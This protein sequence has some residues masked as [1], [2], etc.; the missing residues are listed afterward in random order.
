VQQIGVAR[1]LDYDVCARV[2]VCALDYR[3]L[4]HDFIRYVAFTAVA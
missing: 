3:D 1:L 4:F 2:Y